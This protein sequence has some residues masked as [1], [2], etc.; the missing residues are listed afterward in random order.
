MSDAV[1]EE[2]LEALE[3]KLQLVRDRVRGVAAGFHPGFYLWGRGG[4]S[5][6]FSV[7]AVL[8]ETDTPYKLSNGNITPKALFELLRDYPDIVH[9]LDD[10]EPLL[11]NNQSH[12]IVRAALWGQ[13]G[14]DGRQH[15]VVGWHITRRKEEVEFTGG[16]IFIANCPLADIPQLAAL[17]GRVHP[18]HFHASNREITAFMRKL[19]KDGHRHG[20]D[21][22]PPEVCAEV[23][24]AIVDRTERLKTN[25]DLRIYVAACQ[26]RLQ[27]QAGLAE[28][29]WLDHLDARMR[30]Q[31]VAPIVRPGVRAQTKEAELDFLRRTAGLSPLERL[32]AWRRQTGKSKAALYRRLAELAAD[33]PAL[34]LQR[35]PVSR[36]KH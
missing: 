16:I 15:R 9:V 20:A 2:A 18:V 22:L 34:L 27:W 10:V 24:D 29:H 4:C 19:A 14:G 28:R 35:G 11:L 21:F 1:D 31:V 30:A 3:A 5:K 36:G 17:A 32:D 13:A 8:K 7:E 23:V 26:D 12:G 25:L 6:S 33:E